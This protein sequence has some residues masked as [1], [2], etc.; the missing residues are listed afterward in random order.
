MLAAVTAVEDTSM[1]TV[2]AI[3][4]AT[5]ATGLERIASIAEA[6][7]A[8]GIAEAAIAVGIAEAAAAAGIA[9]ALAAVGIAV[10]L[11]AVGIAADLAAVG[12]VVALATVRQHHTCFKMLSIGRC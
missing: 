7:S 11:A 10:A 3:R 9:V 1:A 12:I 2:E 5:A 8:I 6:A 4:T